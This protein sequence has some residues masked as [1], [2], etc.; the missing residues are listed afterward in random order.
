[1]NIYKIK[2][3]IIGIMGPINGL[4]VWSRLTETNQL[5]RQSK[6]GEGSRK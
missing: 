4:N 1:M 5:I 3:A 2:N 6:G